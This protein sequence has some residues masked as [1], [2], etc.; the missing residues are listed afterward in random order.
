MF[1][2]SCGITPAG[3]PFTTS[4]FGSR[5]A[6]LRYASSFEPIFVKSGPTA[7]AK[8]PILWHAPQAYLPSASSAVFAG[9]GAASAAA[10]AAGAGAA[11][12]P[13]G[14]GTVALPP[15]FV[16]RKAITAFISAGFRPTAGPLI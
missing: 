8:A 5:I 1:P 4:A 10:P 7:P 13:V 3:K 9:A 2:K 11:S 16:C 6:F 15:S 14:S 12:A